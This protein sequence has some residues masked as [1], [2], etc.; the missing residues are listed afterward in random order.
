MNTNYFSQRFSNHGKNSG[1]NHS[2]DLNVK[3][4]QSNSVL[5]D[6]VLEDD[7]IDGDFT[8]NL[9]IATLNNWSRQHFQSERFQP[10]HISNASGNYK[11]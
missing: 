6:D 10:I 1:I 5:Q 7:F 4:Q 11:N 8:K 2:S 9:I 3:Q